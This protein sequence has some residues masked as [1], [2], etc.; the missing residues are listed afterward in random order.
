MRRQILAHHETGPAYL[1]LPIAIAEIARP[2]WLS[3]QDVNAQQWEK[4]ALES[5]SRLPSFQD[6]GF[7][8]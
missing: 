8:Q 3:I 7:V 6:R 2:L 4:P 1:A 5:A